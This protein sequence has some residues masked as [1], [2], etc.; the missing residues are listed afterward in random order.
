MQQGETANGRCCS[1]EDCGDTL[2]GPPL[3]EMCVHVTTRDRVS[4]ANTA[5]NIILNSVTAFT[6]RA[7]EVGIYCVL[8]GV[9]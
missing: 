2:S 6:C 9:V 5:F 1:S 3:E 7:V 8:T 4:F